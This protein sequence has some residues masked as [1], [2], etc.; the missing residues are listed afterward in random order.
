MQGYHD[1]PQA[2][3]RAIDRDGWFDTGDLGWV[4]PADGSSVSGNLVLVGRAKDTIVLSSGENVEPGP[5]EEAL[6]ESPLIRQVMLVGSGERSLGALVV[7]DADALQERAA[8]QNGGAAFNAEEARPPAL[9]APRCRRLH[10]AS[11]A[12]L[13]HYCPPGS[14]L[15]ARSVVPFSFLCRCTR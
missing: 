6:V 12:P 11:E 5:L 3:A 15:S 9:R 14:L 13:L 10:F 1:D 7:P 4:V 2:T 8:N